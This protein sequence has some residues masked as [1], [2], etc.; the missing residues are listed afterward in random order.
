[1]RWVSA[2]GRR[3]ELGEGERMVQVGFA[4]QTLRWRLACRRFLRE[5]SWDHQAWKGRNGS[6]IGERRHWAAVQIQQSPQPDL[7]EALK[8]RVGTS[9]PGLY[10]PASV[11]QWTQAAL[12][13][14]HALGQSGSLQLRLSPK[15]STS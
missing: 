12:G 10:I 9:G 1:M 11:I 8:L 14:R 2:W 15:G 7:W 3:R 4:E 5:C 6:R 13:R